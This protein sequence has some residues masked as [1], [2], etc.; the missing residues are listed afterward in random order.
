MSLLP[1][2][3]QPG[4]AFETVCVS[5]L[6]TRQTMPMSS[7][8]ESTLS[9]MLNA[10]IYLVGWDLSHHP[11]RQNPRDDKYIMHELFLKVTEVHYV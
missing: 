7:I 2:T 6:K 5:L 3:V 1:V 9:I 10:V 4:A 11:L 8:A